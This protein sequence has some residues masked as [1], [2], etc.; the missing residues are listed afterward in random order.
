M[1]IWVSLKKFLRGENTFFKYFLVLFYRNRRIWNKSE[2]FDIW[3]RFVITLGYW[4]LFIIESIKLFDT[5]IGLGYSFYIVFLRFNFFYAS[6]AICF[7]VNTFSSSIMFLEKKNLGLLIQHASKLFIL[8]LLHLFQ[9]ILQK[10]WYKNKFSQ[11]FI[12]IILYLFLNL[13][14]VI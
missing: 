6:L 7:L 14:F 9:N 3:N 10:C 11:K 8:L 1:G 12:R 2:V 5:W 13:N 4:W